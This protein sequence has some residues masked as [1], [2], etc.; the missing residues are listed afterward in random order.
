M[1]RPRSPTHLQQ[2]QQLD[3]DIVLDKTLDTELGSLGPSL[4][5]QI[6]N[7]AARLL[8]QCVLLVLERAQA[9]NRELDL[10]LRSQ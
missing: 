9:L 7:V 4:A 10:D 3:I 5:H 2:L 1:R 6:G 8:C